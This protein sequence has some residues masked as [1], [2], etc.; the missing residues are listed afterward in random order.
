MIW[1]GRARALCRPHRKCHQARRHAS[2]ERGDYSA[3]NAV[4]TALCRRARHAIMPAEWTPQRGVPTKSNCVRIPGICPLGWDCQSFALAPALDPAEAGFE[5]CANAPHRSN[6]VRIPVW[7][8]AGSGEDSLYRLRIEHG[9]RGGIRTHGG[10]NPTLDFESS[11]LNRT[12]PP[13]LFDVICV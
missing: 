2:T 9:G 6:C 5:P 3:R 11:A 12:Q 4:A 13:F 1:G 7:P 10:F 8:H